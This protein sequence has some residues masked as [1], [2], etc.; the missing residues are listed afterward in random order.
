[1]AAIQLS[2]SLRTT[3]NVKQVH[4]IG[5]WDGYQGQL[6]LS[7]ESGSTKW[8]GKFR[9]QPQ[10]MQAGQRYWF[11][12]M[13]D[14]YQ[15]S[16]DPT[17][18]FTREPTTGRNLNILDVPTSAASSS[19]SSR[20]SRGVGSKSSRRY[21]R[22]V[23]QGRPAAEIRSPKPVRPGQLAKQLE[24]Q[25][26]TQ[27]A[28]D[29]MNERFARTKLSD[30]SDED[31]DIEDDSD[32]DVDSDVPSLSSGGSSISGCSSPSSVS[33][34]GSDCT[35]ERYGITRA[36]E[37]VKLDCGGAICGSEQSEEDDSEEE[38][39]QYKTRVSDHKHHKHSSSKHSSRYSTS[40]RRHGMVIR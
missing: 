1:M 15:V 31:S 26:R 14:G 10:T 40:S 5:S 37:R 39:R 19:S 33:S 3:A 16:H 4:L 34:V 28:L 7:R 24:A 2:F 20:S 8:R 25:A 36:G 11:Y 23:P 27:A 6:P 38:A 30:Y 9:F 13:L 12:Y 18:E 22:E 17:K 32:S 29:A 35:C 21:S